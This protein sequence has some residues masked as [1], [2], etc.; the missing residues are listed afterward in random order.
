MAL[1]NLVADGK[2]KLHLDFVHGGQSRL[3]EYL[4]LVREAILKGMETRSHN[5]EEHGSDPFV[6]A[7]VRLASPF[8]VPY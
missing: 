2:D 7:E 3:S 5:G 8:A 1:A 6:P 4:K